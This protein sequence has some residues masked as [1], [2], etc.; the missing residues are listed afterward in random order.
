V[1]LPEDHFNLTFRGFGK[2]LAFCNPDLVIAD[3]WA[4][5]TQRASPSNTII[6]DP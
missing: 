1:L 3:A 6:V 5:L 2:L 4:I